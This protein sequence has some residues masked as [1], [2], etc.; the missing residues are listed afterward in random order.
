MNGSTPL[1]IGCVSE[2]HGPPNGTLP[3]VS[4][5]T[6]KAVAIR[7]LPSLPAIR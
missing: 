2:P 3:V 4:K 5:R 1:E 6:G 7:Y